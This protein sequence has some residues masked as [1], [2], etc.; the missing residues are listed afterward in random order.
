MVSTA[1]H[2]SNS[3]ES[4]KSGVSTTTI[5]ALEKQIVT[6]PTVDTIENT[7]RVLGTD[8]DVLLGSFNGV[9]RINYARAGRSIDQFS[10]S[11]GI[12][13]DYLSKPC[14]GDISE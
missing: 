8:S 2:H 1:Q 6:N 7:A 3:I 4:S 11:T 9:D 14:A 10:Q 12:P 13:V 5:S